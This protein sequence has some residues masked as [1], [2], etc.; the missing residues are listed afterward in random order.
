[1]ADIP[2]LR[3][4]KQSHGLFAFTARDAWPVL[5]G[6]AHL[7]FVC[8]FVLDF[9][10]RP[11]LANIAL[12]AVYA[13]AIAWN[14]NGVSHNFLHTPYFRSGALNRAFG[15]I[16]SLAIGFSQTL[17]R[18][19]H[20]RH[21]VGNAD[22]PGPDGS[23][24][25]PLSIYRHGTDGA[26]EPLWR[27]MLLGA[28]RDDGSA[29]LLA[30]MRRRRPTDADF[31]RVELACVALFVVA[32]LLVDWRAVLFLLPCWY[33]GNALSQLSGYYE[34]L[35]GNP[36]DPIA[37]GVS[38][39][40]PLYNLIWFGNGHHAEHHFRPAIHW[41][42]LPAFHRAIGERQRAAGV[43]VIRTAHWLGFLDRGARRRRAAR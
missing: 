43:H 9:G 12:G 5:A 8:W 13:W 37:W 38:S 34:H 14:I 32:G 23:T 15:V 39:Y 31:V 27:Y 4:P 7:A 25:D 42:R 11:L 18:Q 40:A 30:E 28:L 17:Y 26:P 35:G 21:H 6:C 20:L 2:D 16:E 19:I 3:L 41:T 36:D 24:A 33:L 10:A 29:A 1:M 22:R